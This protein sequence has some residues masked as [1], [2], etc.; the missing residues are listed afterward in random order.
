MRPEK[1]KP[2][3]VVASLCNKATQPVGVSSDPEQVSSTN[4]LLRKQM[5]RARSQQLDK[6]RWAIDMDFTRP[7]L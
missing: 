7:F 5:V 2:Q 1:A 4:P 3:I 6:Q